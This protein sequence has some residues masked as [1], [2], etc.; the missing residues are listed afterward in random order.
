MA[1]TISKK[2]KRFIF[3]AIVII[4]SVCII[5]ITYIIVHEKNNAM[6]NDDWAIHNYG[7]TIE[8]S[9]GVKYI[10]VNVIPAWEKTCG[11]S[12]IIIAVIDT[13]VDISCDIFAHNNIIS[14]WDFYNNDSTTYDR[15]I[16]DYH[17]TYVSGTVAKIAPEISI[18][19][20]KFME[21]SSGS[22]EDAVKSIDFAID[23]GARIINCSWNFYEYDES[24]YNIIKNNPDILFVCAAGN[25]TA[26]LDNTPIYPCSY[27]LDNIINVLAVDNTGKVYSSSGYG[28]KT[29]HIAA[30]GVSVKAVL[31]ENDSTYIDGT[32]VATAFVSAAAG[33]MLS[34]NNSLNPADIIEKIVESSTY[35]EGLESKC[36]SSGLLN[37]YKS[38]Y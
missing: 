34:E 6:Y 12:D 27:G 29:V 16:H 22:I 10:D 36:S 33:L 32:S 30:P 26:N 25:Y 37:V 1:Q 19:P 23:N 15:Y 8:D 21:A 4:V 20:V 13:G 31:P 7:Q 9:K 11:S 2:V 18:L 3:S 38:I 5:A 17:G 14:G 28:E 35:V 24:L